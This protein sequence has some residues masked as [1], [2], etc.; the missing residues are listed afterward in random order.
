MSDSS[1]TA[2]SA[3]VWISPNCVTTMAGPVTAPMALAS[4]SARIRPAGSVATR[5]MLPAPRPSRRTARSTVACRSSPAS[6]VIRGAPTSPSASTSQPTRRSTA[7]RAAA[8]PTVLATWPPVTKP[9]DT[10]AGSRSSSTSQRA[11]TSSTTMTAG[12]A[13]YPPLFWSHAVT[14]QSAPTLA[15]TAPPMTKPK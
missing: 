13:A 14:S 2:S 6:T 10:S 5:Q 12:A 4:A 1:P 9:V 7:C 8:R 3:P 11:V 15:G